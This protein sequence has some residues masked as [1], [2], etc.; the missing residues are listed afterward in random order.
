MATAELEKLR[1]VGLLGQGGSGKTSLGEAMLFA[2]GGTQ[3]VGKVQDGTAGLDHEAE[4]IKHYVSISTAFHSLTLKKKPFQLIDTPGYAAFLADSIN[5]MRAFGGA[6]FVLNPSVGLRVESERL[7]DKANNN[8]IARLF[9]ASKMD[10][11]QD[12][13]VE[14]VDSILEGLEVKGVHL[15]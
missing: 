14:R 3:R 9:F 13:V 8:G 12:N 15:Q 10:H 7:W 4:E 2:A 1:N 5:C 11:E 6:V